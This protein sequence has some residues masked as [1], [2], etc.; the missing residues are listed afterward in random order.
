MQPNEDPRSVKQ[1]PHID[2][3]VP[4]PNEVAKP[5]VTH[6]SPNDSTIEQQPNAEARNIKEEPLSNKAVPQHDEET[7]I[8]NQEPLSNGS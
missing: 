2:T 5:S 3:A 6:V 1:E 4:L 7:R 8:V